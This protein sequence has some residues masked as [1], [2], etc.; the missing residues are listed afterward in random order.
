MPSPIGLSGLSP[1]ILRLNENAVSRND[2]NSTTILAIDDAEPK[3]DA[4]NS[5]TDIEEL[6]SLCSSLGEQLS[7]AMQT[8]KELEDWSSED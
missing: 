1:P 2:E 8:V 6:S 4:E 7:E 3:G 5:D